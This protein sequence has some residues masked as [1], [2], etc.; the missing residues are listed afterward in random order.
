[1]TAE[2]RAVALERA[3]GLGSDWAPLEGS[4]TNQTFRGVAT[5]AAGG[6]YRLE[7]RLTQRGQPSGAG[8]VAALG[9]VEPIGV[10]EVFIIAGQSYGTNCN[11]ATLSVTEPAGR[12]V[13]FDTQANVWRVANDPQPVVDGSNRGSIWPPVGDLVAGVLHVPVGFVNVAVGGSASSQWLPGTPFCNRLIEA[14]KRTGSFRA[15]LWQQGESDVLGNMS[16]EAYAANIRLI[17]NAAV[18]GWK[19]SSTPWLLAK[20]TLHP[21]VYNTPE[22]EGK[23]RAGIDLLCQEAGFR[24]G[25][26]TDLLAGENRGPLGTMRHFTELG[27][28]RAAALWFAAILAELGR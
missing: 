6:W 20:S 18:E 26:D 25:P 24:P 12:V 17:R 28:R 10:G 9:T 1:V 19:N 2:Y 16:T 7:V 14:G 13:A 15:V 8:E 23:I 11:D 4:V 21:T 27:Q 3:W 22:G 5:I